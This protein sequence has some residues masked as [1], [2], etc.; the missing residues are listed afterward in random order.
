MREGGSAAEIDRHLHS[1]GHQ[2]NREPAGC[3]GPRE[4]RQASEEISAIRRNIGRGEGKEK[5][6][7]GLL[8]EDFSLIY[9]G[10]RETHL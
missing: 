5:L 8:F 6:F 2:R 9:K 7:S 1:R 4:L 10:T 3:E